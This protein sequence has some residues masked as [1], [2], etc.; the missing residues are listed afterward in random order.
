MPVRRH[1]PSP[2]KLESRGER[3]KLNHPA[4]SLGMRRPGNKSDEMV[5]NKA[6][7]LRK[8]FRVLNEQNFIYTV[9]KH[10]DKSDQ[11]EKMGTKE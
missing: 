10:N 2:I 11:L 7:F 3:H 8:T 5:F 9:R 4:A 1:T 6:F